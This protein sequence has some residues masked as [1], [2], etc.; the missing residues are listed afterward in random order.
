MRA[1]LAICAVLVLAQPALAAAPDP[2]DD[3]EAVKYVRTIDGGKIV[4]RNASGN[5]LTVRL[6]AVSAPALQGGTPEAFAAALWMSEQLAAA[7]S[8]GLEYDDD[9]GI[10]DEGHLHFFPQDE[11]PYFPFDEPGHGHF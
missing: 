6:L 9:W 10:D 7:E 4:V 11:L 8:L 3:L 2:P 1:L 5:E